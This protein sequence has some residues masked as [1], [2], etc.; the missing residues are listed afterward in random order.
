M[1]ISKGQL[2]AEF[3]QTYKMFGKKPPVHIMSESEKGLFDQ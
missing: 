2:K 3:Y 1:D